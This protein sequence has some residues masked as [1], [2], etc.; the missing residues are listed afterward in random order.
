MLKIFLKIGN[1]QKSRV[2]FGGG[3]EG[4][5]MIY[6]PPKWFYIS[7]FINFFIWG[8]K[9]HFMD[10]EQKPRA[11]KVKEAIHVSSNLFSKICL[12]AILTINLYF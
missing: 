6:N 7:L 12:T 3:A 8:W 2:F 4:G 9:S 11:I 5:F 10:V 1:F